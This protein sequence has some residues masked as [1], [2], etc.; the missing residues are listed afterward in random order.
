[1]KYVLSFQYI[2]LRNV[3]NYKLYSGKV[4][5]QQEKK[6]D[7]SLS[8]PRKDS[9]GLQTYCTSLSLLS[10]F[11]CRQCDA[12]FNI[13]GA[14]TRDTANTITMPIHS[15]LVLSAN[16]TLTCTLRIKFV[17][18][19]THV[20]LLLNYVTE[21]RVKITAIYFQILHISFYCAMDKKCSKKFLPIFL[22]LT[23]NEI[24]NTRLTLCLEIILMYYK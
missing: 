12:N 14:S 4:L 1:M 7:I 2:F 15:K 6:N 18:N 9:P 11:F 17:S 5:R 20:I 22:F 21:F 3:Q 19:Q 16:H 10:S 24:K 23:D 13:L 8:L